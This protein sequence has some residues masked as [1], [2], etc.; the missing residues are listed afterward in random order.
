MAVNKG[1]EPCC[2]D[3][4]NLEVQGA[5]RQVGGMHMGQP[6]IATATLRVCKVCGRKH[7]EL[8][9]DPVHIGVKGS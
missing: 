7:H 9:V 5:P 4:A 8:N 2:A 1:L 3:R 6:S